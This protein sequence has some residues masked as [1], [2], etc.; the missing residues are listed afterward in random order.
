MQTLY[1]DHYLGQIQTA[2]THL[3]LTSHLLSLNT[4]E[5]QAVLAEK[6]ATNPALEL[7]EERRCPQCGRP[8]E[9][10]PCPY[11]QDMGETEIYEV[12][13][14]SAYTK[15][16][17]DWEPQDAAP[18]ALSDYV[19]EQLAP[20]LTLEEQPIARYMVERLDDA[21]YL[22]EHPAEIALYLSRPLEQ[23][24]AVLHKL[25][26]TEPV[27]VG[28]RDPQECLLIQIQH[29]E[30]VLDQWHPLAIDLVRDG[31]DALGQGDF[32]GAAEATGCTLEEVYDAL[33]YLQEHTHPRPGD[34]F[35]NDTRHP[36]RANRARLR[37][38][39]IVIRR[40]IDPITEVEKL[41]VELYAPSA[42][43][44]RVNPLFRQM[45]DGS[46][47][48]ALAHQ[49]SLFIKCI[50]QRN[51]TMNRMLRHLVDRQRAFILHGDRHLEPMT[52]TQLAEEI[53]MHESTISR[54]VGQKTAA[55]PNGRVVPL[56]MFFD[57]SL[58]VRDRIRELIEAE[59]P[60]E[61]LSDSQVAAFLR[62]QGIQIARRTVAKYRN[63]LGI[64]PASLRHTHNHVA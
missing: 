38:P 9:R 39:D 25:Q 62:E 16:D 59:N 11:C 15:D 60:K 50:A 14:S 54:A 51:Q 12:D 56:A 37:E 24:R 44:L 5:L 30:R 42:S 36:G 64:L 2:T 63:R 29:M 61:P 34:L 32:P 21:G 52:R 31:W 33:A 7:V 1:H 45:A 55:L 19:W 46:E 28:A 18:I 10:L 47:W 53:G 20:A 13:R 40:H 49:A 8:L 22:R 41:V 35:W 58:S 23:V 17:D 4:H 43:W 26:Q 3:V 6:L 48:S 27:G 57:R